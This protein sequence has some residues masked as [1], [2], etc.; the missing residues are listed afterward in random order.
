MTRQDNETEILTAQHPFKKL[1]L[2]FDLEKRREEFNKKVGGKKV[3][4]EF[5][6]LCLELNAWFNKKCWFIFYRPE[7]SLERIRAAFKICQERKNKS[8]KY[9]LGVLKKI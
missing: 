3:D 9:F 7:A 4:F 5:Q 2:N 6:E 8:V 1:T